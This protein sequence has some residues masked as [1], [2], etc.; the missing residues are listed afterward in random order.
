MWL[1]S[2]Y[3][4]DGGEDTSFPP[5]ALTWSVSLTS[6]ASV[7]PSISWGSW[8]PASGDPCGLTHGDRL[9]GRLDSQVKGG[10]L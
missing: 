10:P 1:E 4:P 8:D 9:G 7:S 6:R 5:R 2:S 3:L